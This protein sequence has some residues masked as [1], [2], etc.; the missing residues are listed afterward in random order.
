MLTLRRDMV[1]LHYITL[2]YK[3]DGNSGLPS[4]HTLNA[5][6]LLFTHV[7][8]LFGTIVIHGQPPDSV[9]FSTVLPMPKGNNVD[10]SGQFTFPWHSTYLNLRKKIQ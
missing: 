8:S 4:N 7:A 10:K 5:S 3:N 9:L 2:H 6:D 1:Q